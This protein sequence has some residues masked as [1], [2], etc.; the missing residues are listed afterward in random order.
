MELA[1]SSE[2]KSIQKIIDA[3]NPLIEKIENIP[4]LKIPKEGTTFPS[5]ESNI[6]SGMKDAFP[7]T[8][9]KLD[10]AVT[11]AKDLDKTLKQVDI[12]TDS[13]DKVLEK[14]DRTKSELVDIVKITKQS[15]S[16]KDGKFHDSYTLKDSRGSTEIYGINSKTD[17]GQIL[18]QNIVSYDVKRILLIILKH[19]RTLQKKNG[20]MLLKRLKNTKQPYQN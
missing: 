3:L 15:V 20:Q 6:S 10:E 4:E 7:N 19:K 11:S 14:L 2:I 16:D 13:F 5:K 17:K 9:T 8:D 1:A 18:R 12:P